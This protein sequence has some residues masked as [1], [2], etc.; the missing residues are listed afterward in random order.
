[1]VIRI[2]RVS[3]HEEPASPPP[4]GTYRG[5]GTVRGE[6]K[7]RFHDRMYTIDGLEATLYELE[8]ELEKR[9]THQ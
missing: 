4:K 6:K 7:D 2:R 1:M 8:L 9:A 3:G 5:F